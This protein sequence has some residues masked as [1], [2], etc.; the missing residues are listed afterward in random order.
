MGAG[1]SKAAAALRKPGD[2]LNVAGHKNVHEAI[3]TEPSQKASKYSI[4]R[5]W[6]SA[7]FPICDNTHQKLQK[8]GIQCGP[9]MLEVKKTI[10]T[11]S[12]MVKNT[13]AGGAGAKLITVGA[14]G[15]IA[16]MTGTAHWMGVI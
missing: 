7:K 5:C 10:V 11:A 1:G 9:C 2:P 14:A 8:Q 16:A 12:T 15:G 6:K 4:C 13:S 3:I